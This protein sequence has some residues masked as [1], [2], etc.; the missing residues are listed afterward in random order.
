MPNVAFEERVREAKR[1]LLTARYRHLSVH[2]KIV[3]LR[4]ETYFFFSCRAVAL[5]M[6]ISLSKVN[7]VMKAVR[8]GRPPGRRGRPPMLE[9]KEALQ[10]VEDIKQADPPPTYKWI[11][12]RVCNN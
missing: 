11:S 9:E 4:A 2:D 3:S 8:D 5:A 12:E 7:Q 6:D 10:L 1:L